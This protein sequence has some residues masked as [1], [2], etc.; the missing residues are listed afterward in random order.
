MDGEFRVE[1]TAGVAKGI[2][3][4]NIILHAATQ[5]AGL[6]RRPPGGR[7]HR[8]AC[9]VITPFPGG[10]CRSGSKVGSVKYKALKA[11][12]AETYSPVLRQE[13]KTETRRRANCAYELV[14]NGVDQAAVAAA[15][16]TAIEA[17]AGDGIIAIGAGNYGGKLGK[18]HFRLHELFGA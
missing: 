1:A 7:C 18:F 13:V 6:G 3:G 8:T 16:K 14:I 9:G 15:T 4:G 17:A 11:S 5:P 2:A 10:V 12:T